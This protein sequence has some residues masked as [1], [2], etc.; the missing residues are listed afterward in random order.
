MFSSIVCSL[1]L[2]YCEFTEGYEERCLPW[3]R[4]NLET[5]GDE[6]DVTSCDE[7]EGKEDSEGQGTQGEDADP[8]NF[9]Q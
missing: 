6:Q 8:I 3:R 9:F 1:P 4:E 7:D 2:E 5:G